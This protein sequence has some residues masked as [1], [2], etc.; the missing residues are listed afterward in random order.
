MSFHMQSR[1]SDVINAITHVI[2]HA[3]TGI[4]CHYCNRACHSTCNRGYRMSLM[5]SRMSF[6][7][8]SRVSD[9]INAIAHVIQHAIAIAGI[10]CA[11]D[12]GGLGGCCVWVLCVC[13]CVCAC[14]VLVLAYG[15]PGRPLRWLTLLGG[16]ATIVC[17]LD[18]ICRRMHC[19][20][21]AIERGHFRT[22]T[23][24]GN[25][26]SFMGHD[27]SIVGNGKIC[28]GKSGLSRADLS[29]RGNGEPIRSFWAMGRHL[30][31]FG[32][33]RS[34]YGT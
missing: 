20:C 28:P 30:I 4:G 26:K 17:I 3:I 31:Q 1:V 7:M 23:S 2:Q 24:W 15:A 29:H 16:P 32:A 8:Q 5:Q 27:K 19:H 22:M 18:G 14:G 9:V 21:Q 13:A 33:M 12:T 6:N 34:P 10:G 11:N 25:E